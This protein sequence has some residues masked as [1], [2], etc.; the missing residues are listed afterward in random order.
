MRL[1]VFSGGGTL[2]AIEKICSQGL[3]GSLLNNLISL[4]DRNLVTPREG[5]T[6]EMRFTLLG[7]IREINSQQLQQAG[8]EHKLRLLHAAYYVDL[9][10]QAHA[11]FSTHK[12]RFWFAHLQD[13]SDNIRSALSW[14]ILNGEVESGLRMVGAIR[15]YWNYFGLAAEGRR[16][17]EKVLERAH[18]APSN[19]HAGALMA[20][21]SFCAN[22]ADL[23]NGKKYLHEA[24]QIFD[25]L[26]DENN[27]AWCKIFLSGASLESQDDIQ[28]GYELANQS[29]LV[30][31]E[32]ND[33]A[34]VTR[35]YNALGELARL[36][37]DYDAAEVYYNTCLELCIQSGEKLREIF[38]YI[39]LGMVAYHKK[40]FH[41]SEQLHIQGL[42]Q[43][44]EMDS[45]FGMASHLASLAGPTAALGHGLKAARMLG[46]ADVELESLG[47]VQLPTD[48]PEIKLYKEKVKL[49]LG[50]DAYQKA[51]SEGASMNIREAIRYAIEESDS[52]PV[53]EV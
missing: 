48:Q 50:E 4:V 34:G 49:D 35:A 46:A 7:F 27:A 37:A 20:L 41:R 26:G 30:F 44:F 32:S 52:S 39:N 2:V 36:D 22:M 11:D 25:K 42:K 21:G 51:W 12:H 8:E 9:A 19:L 23:Q 43:L 13:E 40:E 53:N 14:M 18:Q 45:S 24:L 1:A 33:T 15:D 38:Q 6:A 17:A 29:L 3:S 10:E 5:R 47:A 16:F 31:Q 28:T